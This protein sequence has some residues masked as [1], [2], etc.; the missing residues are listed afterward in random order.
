[1]DAVKFGMNQYCGPAVL[2]IMT[3]RNT[4]ECAGAISRITGNY[5]VKGVTVTDMIKAAKLLRFELIEVTTYSSTLFGTISQIVG[6]GDGIYLVMVPKHFVAIE[7]KDKQVF[8]CD[9]HTKEPIKAEAA[10]RMGQKVLGV[11][12]AIKF[13][14]K[15]LIGTTLVCKK[16]A[17]HDGFR[18]TIMES[19]RYVNPEDDTVKNLGYLTIKDEKQLKKVFELMIDSITFDS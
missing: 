2:S 13:P 5:E 16:L 1:M 4:D 19:E 7:V 17:L 8:F 3:G 6:Q 9:N 15:E 12:R 10:A 18:L 11:Y 14:E